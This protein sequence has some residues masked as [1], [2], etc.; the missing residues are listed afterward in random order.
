M[1]R[2]ERLSW[3]M[4]AGLA[5]VVGAIT[6]LIAPSLIPAKAP[7]GFPQA[8]NLGKANASARK[9]LRDLD[10]QARRHSGD[11]AAVGELGIGYHANDYFQE[12]EK[13]LQGGRA[14]GARRLPM[15]VSQA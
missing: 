7:D 2:D 14:A 6:W 1:R 9:L 12:A 10:K 3:W 15:A 5:L 8:P 4:T 13:S 11:A